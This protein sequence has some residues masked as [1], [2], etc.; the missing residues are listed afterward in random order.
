MSGGPW[1]Y[2]MNHQILAITRENDHIEDGNTYDISG[3]PLTPQKIV[4]IRKYVVGRRDIDPLQFIDQRTYEC[5]HSQF[6]NEQAGP[7]RPSRPRLGSG[8]SLAKADEPIVF[9]QDDS[10]DLA[11]QNEQTILLFDMVILG[12]LDILLGVMLFIFIV[13]MCGVIA[14]IVGSF[15]DK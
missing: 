4:S 13:V 5:E 15:N 11:K 12:A 1:I 3:V 7:S 8:S 2:P 10:Q 9:I 6:Q 14:I